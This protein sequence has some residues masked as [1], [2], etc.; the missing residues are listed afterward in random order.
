MSL[1]PPATQRKPF[2]YIPILR[3]PEIYFE[4]LKDEQKMLFANDLKMITSCGEDNALSDARNAV[5]FTQNLSEKDF[6][7]NV[8]VQM[9]LSQFVRT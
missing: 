4:N 8:P 9:Q 2:L 1:Q 7:L 5:G 3:K 6:E